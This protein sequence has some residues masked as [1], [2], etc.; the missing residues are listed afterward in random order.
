MNNL[1]NDTY[2]IEKILT[3]LKFISKHMANVSKE[4]FEKNEI[5][6]DSMSFRLIQISENTKQLSESYKINRTDIPWRDISGLRNRLVHDY[7]GVDF[8][9]VY[10]TLVNDVPVLIGLFEK[11]L[12]I[13]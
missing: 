2:Y 13:K 4:E 5:L 3:D 9:I 12:M 1:K 10:S 6:L 7:G 8:E 11:E